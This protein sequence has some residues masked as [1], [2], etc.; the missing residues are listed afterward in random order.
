MA[1]ERKKNKQTFEEMFMSIQERQ[2]ALE[3]FKAKAENEVASVQNRITL[4]HEVRKLQDDGFTDQE[5]A[6]IFPEVKGMLNL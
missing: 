5:I 4:M 3:K 6:S 2:I 1:L